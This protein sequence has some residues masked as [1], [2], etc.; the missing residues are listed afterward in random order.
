MKWM[1]M[2]TA[3]SLL[4]S[5]TGCWSKLEL[6]K[7]SFIF[8][9]F[10]DAAEEPNQ[11]EVTIMA[12]LPNR[13]Q[14]QNAAQGKKYEFVSKS[15]PSITEAVMAIQKDLPRQL[16]FSHIKVVVVGERYAR[17]GISDLLEWFARTP[18]IPVGTSIM[19]SPAKAKQLTD[20][21][22]VFEQSPTDVLLG[23]ANGDFYFKTTI[24]DILFAEAESTAYVINYLSV[25]EKQS[26]GKEEGNKWVGI[27]GG[28][29]FH[30][31]KMTGIVKGEQAGLIGW[32]LGNPQILINSITW[33]NNQN[34]AS[35]YFGNTK[36][37]RSVKLSNHGPVFTIKLKST[38]SVESLKRGHN[39]TRAEVTPIILRKL[40]ERITNILLEAIKKT[41]QVKSD[42]LQLGLLLEWN[43]PK[44]WNKIRHKWDDYYSNEL[45]IKVETQFNIANFGS[46]E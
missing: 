38:V 40:D 43:Y 8:G 3:L 14:Q 24:K 35:I 41:Q 30:K 28:M 18:E 6:D 26:A 9:I 34:A 33:N 23:L 29:L 27:Q 25:G 13:L 22:A 31:G 16:T 2:V 39:E 1:R 19:A 7:V 36:G 37:S 45:D 44:Y 17:H 10:V 21:S 4:L 15:A 42:V 12:P 32:S 5:L 46:K 11:V 20:L